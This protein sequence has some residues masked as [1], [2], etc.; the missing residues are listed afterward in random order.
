MTSVKDDFKRTTISLRPEEYETLRFIAFKRKTSVAGVVR[1][2]IYEHLEDEE[3]IRDGLKALEENADKLDW[4]TF[5]KDYL[6][7]LD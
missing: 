4:Q 3:D 6:G 1:E 2:L 5:K 7:I